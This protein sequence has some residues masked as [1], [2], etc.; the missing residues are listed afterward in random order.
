MSSPVSPPPPAST[1]T[2]SLPPARWLRIG[3]LLFAALT[4]AL[5][6]QALLL[7]HKEGELLSALTASRIGIAADE[8]NATFSRGATNGLTLS[9]SRGI[10]RML[11]RLAANDRDITAIHVFDPQGQVHFSVGAD[12]PPAVTTVTML[13]RSAGL[14]LR[15][16]A[17]HPLLVGQPLRDEQGQL[18]GGVL[19]TVQSDALE[20]RRLA[21]RNATFER[22]GLT[23]VAVALALPLLLTAAARLGRRFALRLRL[24]AAALVLAC[25]SSLTLSLQ[26]LPGFSE[27]LAPALDAKAAA[28]GRFLAGRVDSALALGIP[29]GGLAGVDEYFRD[30]LTRH[31]EILALHLDGPGRSLSASRPGP[32]GNEA[33]TPLAHQPGAHVRVI[34]AGDVVARELH[35]L[36]LDLAI[37]F[38][39][40]VVLFNE[41]LGAILAR[42][43]LAPASSRASLGLARLALFLLILSEELTRAFLPL[44]IASLAPA[45]GTAIG[46]PISAYMLSFAVFT[47]LAGGWAGRYGVGRLFAAGAVLSTGGFLWAMAGTGYWSFVAAR[48]TC[49]AGYAMGT[50][51]MQQYFLGAAVAGERTRALALY[52]GAL[53]TAAVCG[54]AIGGLLAERFGA[55]VVFAG[56]AGLGLLALVIQRFDNSRLAPPPTLAAPLRPMLARARI[57]MPILGAALPAKLALAGFLFYLVPLALHEEGYGSSATGRALLLYFLLAAATNPLGSWLSDRFG[58]NRR[59][60]IGGGLLIGAGGLT[61]L[62]GGP[63]ALVVGIITL[64]IGTGLG[65]APLQSM[66]G[67][68]G[69]PALVLLRTGERLGA[70]A[71]PLFAGSLFGMLAYGGTMAAIG[72]VVFA[73]ILVLALSWNQKDSTP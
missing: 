45:G 34:T 68:D 15:C 32:P 20:A 48:C 35:S 41:T 5:G 52:V 31:P 1:T 21:A 23:L 46:L 54:S 4:L 50:M 60:V 57:W 7:V 64:G 42:N 63:G 73:A 38:V 26:A 25:T 2:R 36:A 72:A 33:D 67:R 12:T 71:G 61:G 69:A 10:G 47:L 11:P 22:L 30:T 43:E 39:V 40:A 17:G 16:D 6:L 24:L 59:L 13:L 51:A 37:V 9:E 65:A 55:T 29:F 66:I 27:Q 62:L 28:L 44:H 49:A 56:A 3:L 53:Q 14:W 19:F 70:V 8:V 58:W 18:A